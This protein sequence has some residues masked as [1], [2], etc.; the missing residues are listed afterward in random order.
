MYTYIDIYMCFCHRDASSIRDTIL[1]LSL[2]LSIYICIHTQNRAARQIPIQD[3]T[4]D[5]E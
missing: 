5:C 1:S 3:T 4:L 2:S